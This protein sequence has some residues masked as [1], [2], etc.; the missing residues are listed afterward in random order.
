VQGK[1]SKLQPIAIK[2]GLGWNPGIGKSITIFHVTLN[3]MTMASFDTYHVAWR[4]ACERHN[5][6]DSRDIDISKA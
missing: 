1:E 4:W 3:G 5:V 6:T 2:R